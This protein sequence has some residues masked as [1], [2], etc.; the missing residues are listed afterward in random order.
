[1]A[2]GERAGTRNHA[3]DLANAADIHS[4]LLL[5]GANLDA[6]ARLH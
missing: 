2:E 6:V 4:G 3:Q 1:M 5:K